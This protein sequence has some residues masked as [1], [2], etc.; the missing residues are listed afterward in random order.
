M[1]Y[2]A[3]VEPPTPDAYTA[4]FKYQAGK[5]GMAI[6]EQ[7]VLNHILMKYRVERR[8][9]KGCE[10]RDILDRATDICLFEKRRPETQAKHHETSRGVIFLGA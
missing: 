6:F 1:G 10:P 2:R 4:I 3:R 5:R 9:M 8:Q 7:P